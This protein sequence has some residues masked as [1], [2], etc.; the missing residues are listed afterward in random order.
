MRN[1]TE[2]CSQAIMLITDGVAQNY[3]DLI[4][5]YNCFNN[6]TI[7]PV[8]IFTYLIG[9]EIN[10]VE[11]IAS[12]AC[13]NRGYFSIVRNLETVTEAVFKYVNVIARPLILHKKYPISWT[14]TSLDTHTRTNPNET[15]RLLTS[16][17]IP[18]YNK[19]EDLE[20]DIHLLGVAGTDVTISSIR[21][22]TFPYKLGVNAHA[23]IVTNNGYVLMHPGLR[24][25]FKNKPTPNY[26]S[27]DFTEV[28]QLDDGS[29]PRQLAQILL[30]L[31]A[32]LIHS[33]ISVTKDIPLKY[34][35]NNMQRVSREKFDFY[36][37]S[38]KSTPFTMALAL[39]NR[40]GYYAVQVPDEIHKNKHARVPI[41]NFF[42]GDNWKIHPEWIYC[43]YHYL[44]GHE[45]TNPEEELRHFLGRMYNKNFTWTMQ[46]S[47]DNNDEED[48]NIDE[49]DLDSASNIETV[50]CDTDKKRL[51]QDD[52]YCDKELINM[53]VFDAKST[54]Q[55][56]KEPWTFKNDREEL[57]FRRY[58]A[59]LRFVAT[60][61]G[62]TRWEYIF[63]EENGTNS[64]EFGDDHP[65][66]IDETWYKSAV[67]QHQY[68]IDSFVYSVPLQSSTVEDLLVTGSY[69]IFPKDAG[70]EAPASVV[71]FQFSHSHLAKSF[72]DIAV[73]N[74]E[75]Q[76]C[77]DCRNN[78]DC[79]IIDNS[80]YIIV[81]HDAVHTGTFF[82]EIEGCVF[83][84]MLELSIFDRIPVYD[85]QSLC[86]RM[87]LRLPKADKC[88]FSWNG[89][90]CI[91]N[92]ILENI[93]WFILNINLYQTWHPFQHMVRSETDNLEEE[94]IIL[95]PT[96]ETD[97]LEQNKT[98]PFVPCD[99]KRN[100]YVLNQ[101]LFINGIG[102]PGAIKTHCSTKRYYIKLIP[103][104]NLVLVTVV[105]NYTDAEKTFSTEPERVVYNDMYPCQKLQLNELTRRRLSGCFNTHEDV[106]NMFNIQN[107]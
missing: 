104:S 42:D 11:E 96:I 16:A 71:G 90:S 78:L 6:D 31:R 27:I 17:A 37:Q 93:F 82:G 86:Y 84:S 30:D 9:K 105:F 48:N 99:H 62:L 21:Q 4:A 43:K 33:N 60:M 35:Y 36:Y 22:L 29:E 88:N 19:S 61:S 26:N 32:D 94:D 2:E 20:D 81:S 107:N 70:I 66:A 40:F 68:D 47:A 69:A 76:G 50:E 80:G 79:Y 92:W 77:L 1:C 59:T 98:N 63:G 56:F 103:R 85:Y 12:I 55:A 10:K 74:M 97:D 24:P 72:F 91:F 57:L 51:Q 7:Q 44:E 13:K 14:H 8:R 53:L 46:Y 39:P 34:H 18:V 102:F 28:Q 3:S 54:L 101:N 100:L 64:R 23:F 83:E 5:K 15:Y 67:L 41:Q 65:R 25:M 95:I 73:T 58:N 75:C 89:M 49:D 87:I 45:F 52:Y 38:I 106:S